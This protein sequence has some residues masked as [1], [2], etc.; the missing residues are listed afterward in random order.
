MADIYR[1]YKKYQEAGYLSVPSYYD[2][3]HNN[4][5]QICGWENRD[6]YARNC[7]NCY[8]QQQQ[9]GR[10]N[11]TIRNL[12]VASMSIQDYLIFRAIAERKTDGIDI[13]VTIDDYAEEVKAHNAEH[14]KEYQEKD[15]LQKQQN[16]T[17]FD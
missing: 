14:I 4:H 3:E 12:P 16:A 10:Q 13:D 9:Y 1:I 8:C 6:G 11:K 7:F 2:K 15:R 17:L 5:C